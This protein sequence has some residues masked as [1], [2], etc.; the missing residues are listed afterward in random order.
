MTLPIINQPQVAI[1]STD[2][3]KKRPVVVTGPDGDDAIAI[4]H[5]GILAL[6][7]DHRA[8]DGAYA[9][10][11]LHAMPSGAGTARLGSR[12]RLMLRARWLGRV[13]YADADQPPA[14]A[15]RARSRRLSPAARAPARVHAR[16]D[17]RSPSTCSSPPGD[18]SAPTLV[19]TDR[20]GDVTY[21]GPGQLV[22]LPDRDAARVA[23]RPARRRG[24]RPHARSGAHRRAGRISACTARPRAP[25]HR[26]CGSATRRSPRSG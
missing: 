20:G 7:W 3:I 1:L 12:A 5:T 9:A 16:D 11:F 17:R 14:G 4:H 26:A 25:A 8:F 15:A 2:G 18:R 22:G 19:H 21:H 6:T 13:P 10:A 23:R 24:V